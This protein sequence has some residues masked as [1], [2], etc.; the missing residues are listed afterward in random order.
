MS[1]D[2][3][4]VATIFAAIV[5][6]VVVIALAVAWR[7]KSGDADGAQRLLPRMSRPIMLLAWA[8]ILGVP[9]AF[10]LTLFDWETAPAPAVAPVVALD[11]PSPPAPEPAPTPDAA[12]TPEPAPAPVDPE[13]IRVAVIDLGEPGDWAGI[14]PGLGIEATPEA[15]ARVDISIQPD[16]A[17]LP[18]GQG[19]AADGAAVYAEYCVACHG[20]EGA[21]GDGLVRLTGGIGTLTTDSPVKTVASFWP[22]ATTIFDYVRRAMPLNAPLS[23]T[24][25][26]VYAVVAYLLS[27]DGII[28]A[29]VVLDAETLPLVE[30]PNKDG[31]VLWWPP[32]VTA[33]LP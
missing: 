16:G 13:P 21:G 17:N 29:D 6:L 27:V 1:R 30:M 10:V 12:P 33:E 14:G 26:Q 28:E 15:V 7:S 5:A 23:M 19:T 24:D 18:A 2:I 22:Y 3:I 4:L 8:A 31:F 32:P 9:I 20:E 11:P 25:E